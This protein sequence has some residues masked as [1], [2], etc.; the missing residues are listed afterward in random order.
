MTSWISN[1]QGSLN[2]GLTYRVLGLNDL[3]NPDEGRGRLL[4]RR[5]SHCAMLRPGQLVVQITIVEVV[6]FGT[7]EAAAGAD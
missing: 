5:L 2:C 6:G 3:A 4:S 1:L 7:F